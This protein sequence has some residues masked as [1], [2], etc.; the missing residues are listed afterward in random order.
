MQINSKTFFHP[1]TYLSIS[2]IICTIILAVTWRGNNKLNQVINVTGSAKKE[3]TA[4]F[5]RL[6]GT[7]SAK[8]NSELEAYNQ[9]KNSKI[10]LLS[11]LAKYGYTPKQLGETP[12]SI[13]PVFSRTLTPSGLET[14]TITGYEAIT[15]IKIES[16]E[17]NKMFQLSLDLPSLVESNVSFVNLNVEYHCTK[18]N[19]IKVAIQAEAAK[20]AYMRAERI[21]EATGS[22]IGGIR[23]GTMGVL[24]ITPKYSTDVENGGI[25]DLTSIVKEITAVVNA[26]FEVK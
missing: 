16:F 14:T 2:I 7:L 11:F 17:P 18:L 24:Q 10:T 5:A 20:N 8:G 25:N 22:S 13:A 6:S 21:A 1:L 15:I 23:S 12:I 3:I 9:V 26:S 19:E 4:D